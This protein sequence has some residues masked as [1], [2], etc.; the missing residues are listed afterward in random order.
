M[1]EHQ[2]I[3]TN[4]NIIVIGDLHA[5]WAIAALFINLKLCD[6]N[7]HWIRKYKNCSG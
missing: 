2:E 3:D 7:K 6:N 4:S 5:D 1:S